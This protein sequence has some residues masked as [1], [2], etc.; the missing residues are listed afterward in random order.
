[1]GGKVT[2]PSIRP[3]KRE[4]LGTPR[5]L[6]TCPAP[7]RDHS[8]LQPPA[9]HMGG[10]F[11]AA[12][13]GTFTALRPSAPRLHTPHGA[14]APLL[15]QSLSPHMGALPRSSRGHPHPHP[16]RR[17]PAVSPAVP[18]VPPAPSPALTARIRHRP[19]SAAPGPAP[20]SYWPLPPRLYAGTTTPSVPRA[21]ALADSQSGAWQRPPLPYL[22][23]E[24]ERKVTSARGAP[25]CGGAAVARGGRQGALRGP[26]SV[27]ACA[28]SRYRDPGGGPESGLAPKQR[29]WHRLQGGKN[30]AGGF[31]SL[32]AME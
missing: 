20:A 22:G 32:S 6:S 25:H 4:A 30:S 5:L 28:R 29:V 18:R 24:A 16:P 8:P 11:P 23:A 17:T 3:G 14:S 2:G 12:A 31:C 26:A 7:H 19:A 27:M 21:R 13:P 9:S 1:M 15:P 10:L